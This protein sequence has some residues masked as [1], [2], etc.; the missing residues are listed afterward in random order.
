MYEIN[1][2]SL[3]HSVKSIKKVFSDNKKHSKTDFK[4]I[5]F[6]VENHPGTLA[7]I[8]GSNNSIKG[9]N[10]V[11]AVIRTGHL[12]YKDGKEIEKNIDPLTLEFIMNNQDLEVGFEYIHERYYH[13][14]TG[15]IPR[16]ILAFDKVVERIRTLLEWKKVSDLID[17]L[18]KDDIIIFD[19][20]LISGE[21]STSHEYFESLTSRAKKK[22]I[23]LVGLSKDTS[24]SIDSSSVRDVLSASSKLHLPD[25]NWFVNYEEQGVF[26]V[27][28]S[29]ARDIIY[30][31][32][33][34]VPDH[35][36]MEKVVSWVGSYAFSN[37]SFGYPYP[38]Q[39]IHESVLIKEA[40]KDFA[41]G[42]FKS[43]ALKNGVS[44]EEFNKMFDI[45]HDRMDILSLGR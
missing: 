37:F 45:Y 3:A 39:R 19:G 8:D 32:D 10:F 27:R 41:F 36:T 25:S 2:D 35:L 12:L 38:M 5:P 15:E 4:F 6:T 18:T 23:I 20:S 28:F 14:I 11:L 29:H 31:I 7:A 9:I 43:M 42:E 22:G 44:H 17:R 24:L 21:I 1:R 13:S 30:R 33:A 16:G 40:Q 26:F 34:V